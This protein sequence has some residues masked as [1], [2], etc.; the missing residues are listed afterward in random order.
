[1]LLTV[2]VFYAWAA[3][4]WPG[5][6]PCW[7]FSQVFGGFWVAGLAMLGFF[8]PPHAAFRERRAANG[9]SP[10]LRATVPRAA[11]I[12]SRA[13]RGAGGACLVR[14]MTFMRTYGALADIRRGAPL[15]LSHSAYTLE[16]HGEVLFRVRMVGIERQNVPEGL[17]CGSR[18]PS[19][20]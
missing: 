6:W 20:L 8:W 7:D 9:S 11:N 15:R 13:R 3:P 16:Q 1:M 5:A 10:S 17:F 12:C 14:R 2:R 4:R 19:L 18:V